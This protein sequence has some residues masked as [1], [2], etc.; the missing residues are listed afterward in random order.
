MIRTDETEHLSAADFLKAV[1]RARAGEKFIYAVGEFGRTMDKVSFSPAG[2]ELRALHS[3]IWTTVGNGTVHLAQKRVGSA[4]SSP[5]VAAKFEY[6]AIK[7]PGADLPRT[8][9]ILHALPEA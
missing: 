6:W 4:S 8:L 3:T 7:R 5:F 9:R 2:R 1:D